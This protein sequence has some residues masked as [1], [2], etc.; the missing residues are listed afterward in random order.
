M[1]SFLDKRKAVVAGIVHDIVNKDYLTVNILGAPGTGKTHLLNECVRSMK[2][3][4]K[5]IAVIQLYGDAGK[6]SIPF[7]PFESYLSRK[8]RWKKDIGAILETVPYVG[9]ILG[10]FIN[11]KDVRHILERDNII[12]ENE[13]LSKYIPFSK[14]LYMLFKSNHHIVIACDDFQYI[15]TDTIEYLQNLI[16]LFCEKRASISILT[17][18]CTTTSIGTS[19]QLLSKYKTKNINIVYPSKEEIKSLL[20]TWDSATNYTNYQVNAIY[21]AT[22]GHMLLLHHICQYLNKNSITLASTENSYD[23]YSDLINRR[24]REAKYSEIIIQILE[25]LAAI[26]RETSIYEL[27]CILG[28]KAICPAINE[29]ISLNFLTRDA[30]TVSFINDSL[31]EINLQ[32]SSLDLNDFYLRYSKCLKTLMPSEYAKRSLVEKLAGHE[33]QSQLLMGLYLINQIREGYSID[34]KNSLID[35]EIKNAVAII[36]ETYRLAFKGNNYQGIKY[37]NCAI[38]DIKIPLLYVEAKYIECVLQFKTSRKENSIDAL[39]SLKSLLDNCD[40]EEFELK[41]RLIRLCISLHCSLNQLQEARLLYKEYRKDLAFRMEYDHKSKHAYYELLLLSDSIFDPNTSH[42]IL[43]EMFR[44]LEGLINKG[45]IEYIVLLYKTL[46]NLSSNC[47]EISLYKEAGLYAS[48]ALHIAEN[49]DYMQFV[50]LGAAFN[51]YLLAMKFQKAYSYTQL[52]EEFRSVVRNHLFEED[53]ILIRLNYAGALLGDNRVD[54]AF[55]ALNTIELDP[56]EE[57]DPYY[58]CYYNINKSIIF[59]LLGNKIQALSILRDI[60][61]LVPMISIT[62]SQ[63]YQ[64]YYEVLKKM[65]CYDTQYK[66]LQNMQQTFIE[67]QQIFLSPNWDYFKTVYLFSDLQIWSDF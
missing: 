14:E 9:S 39:N 49:F 34:I 48:K 38:A 8:N 15:D 28:Q 29:A 17:T 20:Q 47:I 18:Y 2:A 16:L 56:G 57:Y 65:M 5:N 60:E 10:Y 63:Y 66:S 31:R 11:T 55:L 54:D 44:E 52:L 51:N 24:V 25:S 27:K 37:I 40:Q 33:R 12:G 46:V 19:I 45:K 36:A 35:N 41:G 58:I 23:Y 22:G 7:Y 6:Q 4:H 42:V 32:N 30:S 3:M 64:K 59:Y 1:G 53:E 50:N 21:A 43:L 13:I 67:C 62:R 26:G 61:S